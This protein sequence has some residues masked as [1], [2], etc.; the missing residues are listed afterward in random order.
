MRVIPQAS[1]SAPF[2]DCQRLNWKV[3]LEALELSG[4]AKSKSEQ[5]S[6]IR[7]EE[8]DCCMFASLRIFSGW[9]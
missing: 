8:A 4:Q 9:M 2:F 1:K 5:E 7:N 3:G 6:F